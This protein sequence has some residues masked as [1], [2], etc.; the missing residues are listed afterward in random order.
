MKKGF[1]FRGKSIS[2]VG[3][4]GLGK[5]TLSLFEFLS[6]SYEGLTFT[7]RSDKKANASPIFDKTFFGIQAKEKID[8]D[9]LFLSPSVRRDYKEFTEAEERGVILS[10]EVEFFFEN[11]SIPVIA[12]TGTDGKSTTVSLTSQMLSY[13]EDFP[14]SANIGLP[15]TSLL[16]RE[17]VRGTV[18]ELSSFQLMNFAPTSKRALITNISEN[19]LD[20][21]TSMDEYVFSKENVLK[22]TEQRVFNLDCPYNRQLLHRYPAYAVFS[23]RLTQKEMQNI[24]PANHYFGLE[25]GKILHSGDVIS[26]KIPLQLPGKYNLANFLAA[27]ALSFELVPTEK[28]L[29][30]AKEF[31]GLAHRITRV[32]EWEGI[33]YIDSSID[34]TPMRTLKTLEAFT[35]PI[36]L[37]LGGRGKALSYEP[38][39]HLPKNVKAVILCG[40]NKNE[41]YTA[42]KDS[43][44]IIT[45]ANTFSE[46]VH[47][48]IKTARRGDTVLLS[49]ASTSFDSFRSYE[50]RGLCFA[51]TVKKYYT[52]L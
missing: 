31:T 10:S 27:M 9:I 3:F 14:A 41:I 24:I 36:V 6:K 5:S 12:V 13:N 28:I 49:P 37:I 44:T 39:K 43:N 35:S 19:H 48:A 50:E 2:S 34:S 29:E 47:A 23:T 51:E 8:E 38:L 21:H 17:N 32:G 1:T 40:D 52:E 16:S 26:D 4:F 46:A 33:S 15:I 22:N 30:A 45:T 42:L 7:L 11:K 25:N 18:A 20:W